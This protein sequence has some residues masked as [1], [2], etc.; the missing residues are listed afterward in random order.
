MIK[1]EGIRYCGAKTKI[2]PRILDMIPADVGSVLD[3]FS[4]ST[5]V[6]QALKQVIGDHG[7]KYD[8]S[9]ND[10]SSYSKVFGECYLVNNEIYPDLELLNHLNNLSGID[11]WFTENYGGS[12]DSDGKKPWQIHNTRKLDAILEE[13]NRIE[14]KGAEKS[15]FLTS[16]IL[17]LDKVDN[18]LGHQVAFLRGWSKRSYDT[19]HMEPPQVFSGNRAYKV[20]QQD[21]KTI[22]DKFDL[23]YIDPPYG[24]NRIE[25][26]TSRVRYNS[27]YHIWNTIC[28]N[29]K[30]PLF[31][32]VN[33]RAD[34]SDKHP[35]A[36]SDFESVSYDHVFT[37]I[38]ETVNNLDCKYILFSYNNKSKVD[39]PSLTNY[40]ATSYKL[41]KTE[42]FPFAENVQKKLVINGKYPGDD[43]QNME[44]LFLIEKV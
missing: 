14:F 32:K 21:A 19:F 20:Y 9:S 4:G 16:L 39:I 22:K 38:K 24:T 2:I 5:R 44:Y 7:C 31:G 41:L 23:I 26:I 25:N 43:K 15:V 42:S 18:T 37:S 30:P 29:D 40:F 13:L 33:R 12:S 27:Y 1:T 34:S 10:L 28:K 3:A 36:L 8:V 11:G 17:A 35:G 6:A